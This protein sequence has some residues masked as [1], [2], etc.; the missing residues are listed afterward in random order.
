VVVLHTRNSM[1]MLIALV[2]ASAV[3][4]TVGLTPHHSYYCAVVFLF[5]KSLVGGVL[6]ITRIPL[7]G[8]MMSA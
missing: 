8:L 5:N 6:Y 7:F 1:V 3:V 2:T 4:P